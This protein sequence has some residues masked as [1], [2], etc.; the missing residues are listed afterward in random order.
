MSD[1]LVKFRCVGLD[2]LHVFLAQG[3]LIQIWHFK[4]FVTV[5]E[6]L[7]FRKWFSCW[8]N[9]M[10][11]IQLLCTYFYQSTLKR[12]GMASVSS[13]SV[14]SSLVSEA[15]LLFFP[16]LCSPPLVCS[17]LFLPVLCYPQF[18]KHSIFS[19]FCST[20]LV[21]SPPLV[22][23]SFLNLLGSKA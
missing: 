11:T 19:C 1:I 14:L 5:Q 8:K 2:I 7:E 13:C 20:P 22:S 17:P 9:K 10:F 18:L 12:F 3:D 21:C 16:A 15:W 23:N 6:R 4:C